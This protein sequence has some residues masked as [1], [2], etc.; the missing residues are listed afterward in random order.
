[1]NRSST[2]SVSNILM[3]GISLI[4][5]NKRDVWPLPWA[6]M[7]KRFWALGLRFLFVIFQS[8]SFNCFKLKEKWINNLL[9]GCISI[10]GLWPIDYGGKEILDSNKKRTRRFLI[11][12]HAES[13]K[14]YL[15]F[16][17]TYYIK[18]SFLYFLLWENFNEPLILW[19]EILSTVSSFQSSTCSLLKRN[20]ISLVFV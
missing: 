19:H 5:N 11:I 7:L 8:N 1:M 16:T 15:V 2:S 13:H 9:F 4:F 6:I 12:H 10:F 20:K 3:L 18:R 14:H 17:C